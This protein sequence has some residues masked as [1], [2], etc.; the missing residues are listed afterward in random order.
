MKEWE[1]NMAAKFGEEEWDRMKSQPPQEKKLGAVK[2]AD[3]G[4][5]MYGLATSTLAA[6]VLISMW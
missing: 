1:E 6:V 5:S 4:A 3:S 2:P